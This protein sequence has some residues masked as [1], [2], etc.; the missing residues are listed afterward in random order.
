[1]KGLLLKDFKLLKIYNIAIGLGILIGFFASF[2]DPDFLNIF[3]TFGFV[4]SVVPIFTS[5]GQEH[6]CHWDKFALTLA[7]DRKTILKSKYIYHL[8]STSA[9]TIAMIAS[10]LISSLFTENTYL[11]EFILVFILIF[12]IA[13][14]VN[15]ITIP[16]IY[17]FGPQITQIITFVFI[18]SVSIFGSNFIVSHSSFIVTS[19]ITTFIP[20]FFLASII[21]LFISYQISRKLILTIEY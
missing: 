4:F 10:T 20:L 17:K 3:I 9:I 1:M 18:F 21:I 5:I 19:N 16:T 6:F 14:L 12:S 2:H 11:K 15:A 13:N 7:L 8:L